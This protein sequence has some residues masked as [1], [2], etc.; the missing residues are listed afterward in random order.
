MG[1]KHCN[2]C[3]VY[4]VGSTQQA[5]VGKHNLLYV[6][7]GLPCW[8][9]THQHNMSCHIGWRDTAYKSV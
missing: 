4:V 2:W 7:Q 5:A 3:H 6:L 9:W 8:R 1:R